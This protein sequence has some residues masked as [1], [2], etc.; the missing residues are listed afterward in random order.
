[1]RTS[2]LRFCP[3]QLLALYILLGMAACGGGS[4]DPTPTPQALPPAI[5][6]QPGNVTVTAGS[7][8]TFTVSASGTAPISYQWQQSVGSGGT[9]T[10]ATGSA[11]GTSYTS[12]LTG[13][14]YNGY[15]YRVQVSNSVGTVTSNEALLTVNAPA[16]TERQ[17]NATAT[18][19]AI[20]AIPGTGEAPHVSINPAPGVSPRGKLL[21]FLPGTLGRPSQYVYILRAGATR[22][23]HSIG[24]NYQNQ[25]AMGA[26]CQTSVDPA[27]YWQARNQVVFGS[28][29]PVSGQTAVSTADSIVNRLN[30]LLVWLNTNQP[31]ENWGQFLLPANTVDWSKVVLAG[32]S[33]GGGHV[34]V[35]VKS[36]ALSRAVYFSSPEDWNELT[37]QPAPW[38]AVRPNITPSSQQFGFGS[39]DDTLV[40]NAHAFTHWTSLG[41]S[42][43]ASGPVLVDSATSYSGSQQLHTALPYNPASSALTTGLK[44]HGVPV[45][46][47]STP[48]DATG[49]PLF[50]TNGVWAYLCFQ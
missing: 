39:D 31:G 9:W 16:S 17:V 27:C 36:V 25:T 26:L 3:H 5:T 11:S 40:P 10:N 22:G 2:A 37:D 24:L 8:A 29:L 35:L 30:K 14:A 4:A 6:T 50:D 21:V 47:V 43:P 34:A 7:A 13:Q 19:A 48:L 49:K 46:D 45:V 23:F 38:I 15:R 42:K 32:H 12:P 44:Y 41:L 28:G 18:D 1:M 33:Q 20:S